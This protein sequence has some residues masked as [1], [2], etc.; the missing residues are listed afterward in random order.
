MD[1]LESAIHRLK[2]AAEDLGDLDGKRPNTEEHGSAA[3]VV[4]EVL[5]DLNALYR[6]L[7]TW[8]CSHQYTQKGYS[9]SNG[10][11]TPDRLRRQVT[12]WTKQAQVA[13][14]CR[15]HASD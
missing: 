8:Q 7:D 4:R 11:P 6:D 14:C 5:R 3:F 2:L 15:R 10:R 12:T 1:Q 9:T 13:P